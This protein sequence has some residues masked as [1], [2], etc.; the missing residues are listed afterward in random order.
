MPTVA[1]IL[2]ILTLVGTDTPAFIALYNQVVSAM[3]QT[4]QQKLKDAY[5]A[6]KALS[7]AQHEE[8]QG[9]A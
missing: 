9:D 5:A 7:D 8:A 2:E 4:D 3:S 1:A 6:A